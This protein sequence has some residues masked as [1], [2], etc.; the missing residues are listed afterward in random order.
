MRTTV[1]LC[2]SSHHEVMF[3]SE[4]DLNMGFNCLAL[5][6]LETDSRLLAEGFLTTHYH[7]LL[8]TDDFKALMRKGR[9]AYSRYFNS[10]YHRKGRLGEKQFFYTEVEGLYHTTA[11]LNYVLRQGFHHGLSATP[12]GYRHCS[13]N[14]FFRTALGKEGPQRIL[15]QRQRYRFL[16]ANCSLDMKFRMSADGLI[17]REDVLDTRYVEEIYITPRN[18]LFQ[19]N[20]NA[21]DKDIEKQ[22]EENDTPLITMDLIETGV[23]DF[24][25]AAAKNNE[26]GK[27]NRNHISDLELCAYIDRRIVPRHFPASRE[28]ASIYLLSNMERAEICESLWQESR[29]M[30]FADGGKNRSFFAGRYV[31]ESQL[32]R[33]MCLDTN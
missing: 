33:C 20:R 3:R 21:G 30:R 13:A 4:A 6:A 12:F 10:K 1:H 16:P 15:P 29:R 23:P 2:L 32:R 26:F 25:V 17:L 9:Y 27:I 11:A 14:S 22:R 8:Q 5:A 19:M 18:Y 24:S 7:A 31:T 28:E